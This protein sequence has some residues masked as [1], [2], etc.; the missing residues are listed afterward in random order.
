MNWDAEGSPASNARTALPKLAR[1][2]FETGRR[3]AGPAVRDNDLHAFR[4]ETKHF[5]YTLELF[6]PVYG[7]GLVRLI[8]LLRALQG[9]LGDV[10]DCVIAEAYIKKVIA[11]PD[12]R[13]IV[14]KHLAARAQRRRAKFRCLWRDAFSTP[15]ERERWIRYLS[16]P[17]EVRA[18]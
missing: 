13:R 12:E 18:E 9:S 17:R 11:N 7:P 8:E 10:N 3:A 15:Q 4:L 1:R 14:K 6:R 5:R 2:W 16:R